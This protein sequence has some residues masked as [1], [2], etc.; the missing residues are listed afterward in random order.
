MTKKLSESVVP[1]DTLGESN[2]IANIEE[3]PLLLKGLLSEKSEIQSQISE[4]LLSMALHDKNCESYISQ[5]Y[6]NPLVYILKSKEQEHSNTACEA[7]SKLIRKSPNIKKELVESGFVQMVSFALIEEGTP[8]HVIVNIL[9]IILDLITTGADIRVMGGLLPS[10]DKLAQEEESKLQ[11]ITTKAQIIQTILISKGITGPSSSSEIQELKRIDEEQQRM[12]EEQKRLNDEQKKQ[13]ADLRHKIEEAKP[14][15]TDVAITNKAQTDSNTK[16]GSEQT[17]TSNQARLISSQ[18]QTGNIFG[19]KQLL[20]QHT[21][22]TTNP[23]VQ[24]NT[25]K[26][27]SQTP[28]KDNNNGLQQIQGLEEM[29][30]EGPQ[31]EQDFVGDYEDFNEEDYNQGF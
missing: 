11:E 6:L 14:K 26:N 19:N 3:I 18:P 24:Q 9:V 21:P 17:N 10:L 25:N 27:L 2:E 29:F 8:Q 4:R 31:Q 16:K 1:P 30:N 5:L 22:T 13:I 28:N 12:I 23:F 15:K 20:A 7:L